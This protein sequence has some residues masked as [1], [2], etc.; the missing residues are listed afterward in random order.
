M[1]ATATSINDY[2][3]ISKHQSTSVEALILR[4]LDSGPLSPREL[5]ARVLARSPKC[6][7]I[8]VKRAVWRLIQQ[9]EILLS[10]NQM[11]SAVQEAA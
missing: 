8:E 2:T 4:S 9:R 1:I 6:T 3:A 5:V 10:H 7:D 11:L